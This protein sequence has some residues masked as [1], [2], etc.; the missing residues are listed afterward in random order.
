[1][2]YIETQQSNLDLMQWYLALLSTAESSNPNRCS[3]AP[4]LAIPSL[5]CTNHPAGHHLARL[6]SIALWGPT[7]IGRRTPRSHLRDTILRVKT[8]PLLGSMLCPLLSSMGHFR[9]AT[10]RFDSADPHL[11][12]SAPLLQSG[13]CLSCLCPWHLC[14]CLCLLYL[15]CLFLL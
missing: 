12:H 13:A 5:E 14:P 4:A 11:R 9:T 6:R 7:P 2:L 1:M 10:G 8:H 3:T 15:S